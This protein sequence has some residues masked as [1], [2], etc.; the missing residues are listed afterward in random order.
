M[1]KLL[2]GKK[3]LTMRGTDRKVINT[4]VAPTINWKAKVVCRDCNVGWMS[5]LENQ[6]AKPAMAD[7][8]LGKMDIPIHQTR[9]DS[10]AIFTFKTAVVLDHLT[11]DREPFFDR[12]IRH[13][14]RESL[15]VPLHV[16]MWLNAFA[17]AGR[18]EANTL[19][20]GAD[21]P[22]SKGIEMY[23]CTFLVQHLVL[24]LVAC[25]VRGFTKLVRKDNFLAVPFWPKLPNNVVWPPSW[26]ITTTEEFD[27]FSD[28]WKELDA[29]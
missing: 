16:H 14:F 19:Y 2:P 12:A 18:G 26:A 29:S 3:R 4:R 23:V 8:M 20:Q 13:K 25:K 24:Q 21:L 17:P 1:S 11:R 6:H 15:A 9:A 28:G 22:E 7:L 5:R 27:L 10:L